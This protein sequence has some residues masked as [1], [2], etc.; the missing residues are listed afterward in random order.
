[1]GTI[2]RGSEAAMHVIIC[3]DN[4]VL[5]GVVR[6]SFADPADRLTICESGMELLAAVKALVSDLV[7]LD[8]ET[9]GPGGL[10][11]AAAVQE[12]SPGLRMV[13]VSMGSEIDARPLVQRGIPYLRLGGY[14]DGDGGT[15][16]SALL[17]R[18]GAALS[19]GPR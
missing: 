1:V 4:P 16:L 18:S 11:L 8:L 7:I 13:A 15:S 12:L 17:G 5:Q 3:S 14:G 19:A 6:Q 10:L 9:H 2:K